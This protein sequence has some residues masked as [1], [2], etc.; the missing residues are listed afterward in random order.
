MRFLFLTSLIMIAPSFALSEKLQSWLPGDVAEMTMWKS[1]AE[2]WAMK[3]KKDHPENSSQYKQAFIY[4]TEAKAAVDAWISMLKTELAVS[5]DLNKSE[6]YNHV[7]NEAAKKSYAFIKYSEDL[8][9]VPRGKLSS[10]KVI[11]QEFTNI[12]KII[13]EEYKKVKEEKRER[14]KTAIEDL[15]WKSFDE[16]K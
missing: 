14:I 1:R 11:L 4:Y 13:W 6:P 2:A 10:L 15:R 7:L 12:A 9:V 8:Y 16:I 5:G 3:I